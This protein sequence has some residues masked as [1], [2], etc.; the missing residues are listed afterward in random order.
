MQKIKKSLSKLLIYFLNRNEEEI[1]YYPSRVLIQESEALS[2]FIDLTTIR[3]TFK[4]KN[5]D[6]NKIN[7]KIMIDI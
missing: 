5:E 1:K 7:P 6:I 3:D 4:N 2:T